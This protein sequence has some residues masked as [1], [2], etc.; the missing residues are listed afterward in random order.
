M[1]LLLL[2]HRLRLSFTTLV[3]L[4]FGLTSSAEAKV[5]HDQVAQ[6]LDALKQASGAP[7]R[8]TKSP[9]T[10]LAIFISA[11]RSHPM[12]FAVAAGAKPE[13]IALALLASAGAAIGIDGPQQVAVR[14]VSGPD[15]VGMHHVRLQQV[16]NGIP[17]VGAEV[18]VHL[19]GAG[20]VSVTAK[21][22]PDATAVDTT[23]G[24]AA[25]EALTAA[26][27]LVAQARGVTNPT[28]SD[29]RLEILS[30]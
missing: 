6:G 26:R 8:V 30:P 28:L 16:Q 9:S 17:V 5:S 14:S 15:D 11:D 19:A 21:T 23:P 12:R 3:I 25:A 7:L 1:I 4:A 18:V 2:R 13:Q 22:V 29:P 10:G 27:T 24:I 20:V